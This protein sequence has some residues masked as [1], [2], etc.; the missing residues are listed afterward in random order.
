MRR[1]SRVEL[2]AGRIVRLDGS[3]AMRRLARR[4]AYVCKACLWRVERCPFVLE[5]WVDYSGMAW[6]DS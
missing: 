3:A 1:Y 2:F 5:F 6:Y 4:V